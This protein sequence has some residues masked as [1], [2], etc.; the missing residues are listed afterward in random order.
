MAYTK[1]IK[2]N[3]SD[4]HQTSPAYLLT[5]L[6]WANRDTTNFSD[7]DFLELRKPMLVVNDCIDLS[8]SSSKANHIHTAQMT[9][10]AGDI[11]YST[12]VAP[13]DFVMVNMLDNDEHLFGKGGTATKPT[14]DSLYSRATNKKPINHAHDGF[15][16]LFKI[17][18]VTRNIQVNP[19]SGHKTYI[20]QISAAAFTEFNQVIYFNPNLQD[21]GENPGNTAVLNFGASQEWG[22]A[23]LN[24]QININSI[25]KTLVSFLLGQGFNSNYVPQKKE[26]IRNFN[27]NFLVPPD[28]CSLMN[29]K[30]GQSPKAADLFNYYVGIQKYAGGSTEAA[31][32]NPSKYSRDGHYLVSDELT[33]A[34]LL[35]GEPFGQVTAWSILSQY[36]NSLI[37][38]MYT[39]YKLTPE[40]DVMPCLVL[41]QKP[42]TSANFKFGAGA[43][44]L[45]TEFLSLPR[46][47][48][49]VDLI[50]SISL[51][52]S[53][54]AR[55]N[56][57][58]IIGKTREVS[59]QSAVSYQNSKNL[60]QWDTQDIKRNG[61]RP[62]ITSCD[63][64]FPTA[65]NGFKGYSEIWNLLYADWLFN[66]HLKENGTIVC[67]GIEEAIAVGD[68]LQLENTV[69]H[70]ESI[71][72]NMG[73]DAN[74]HKHFKTNLALSFGVD[75]RKPTAS[76]NPI[77]PEMQYTDSY[78]NRKAKANSGIL[79]GFSDAQDIRGRAAGEEVNE[80]D[81]KA[82]STIPKKSAINTEEDL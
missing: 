78:T 44:I 34:V 19:Q 45:A 7:A 52:R 33:G 49:S 81:E 13:G 66:G 3:T 8:V 25:F 61:L 48:V 79:P 38:E 31:G 60:H 68:N 56:F 4:S 62:I 53:D 67:A 69:Y 36:S 64:D 18:T 21:A 59:L 76:Y 23:V 28:V 80:T 72:H 20:F 5:F 29:I 15:K 46:W 58:H 42:F 47:K 1:L 70:I 51:G 39:T 27:K 30:A 43:G 16:G 82:F 54:A 41:R 37:N 24:K 6:R 65:V 77:Y 2:Q 71:S 10:L 50:E 12:A 14:G 63:F 11:N 73:I 26:L 75:D 22:E 55:V 57:V 74:G 32:L 40:G 35:Q 17:Q 9:L